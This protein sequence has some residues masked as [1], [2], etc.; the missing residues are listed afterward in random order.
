MADEGWTFLLRP[1]PKYPEC[2]PKTKDSS[3]QLSHF[4]AIHAVARKKPLFARMMTVSTKVTV[5]ES[6]EEYPARKNVTL[7]L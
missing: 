6:K 7:S 1:P 4:F 5:G 3:A 2:T